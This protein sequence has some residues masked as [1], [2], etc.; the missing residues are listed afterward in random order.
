MRRVSILLNLQ[1]IF[2]LTIQWVVPKCGCASTGSKSGHPAKWSKA[3]AKIKSK[4]IIMSD[5][6]LEDN[7]VA[8]SKMVKGKNSDVGDR[9]DNPNKA[10]KGLKPPAVDDYGYP[11]LHDLNNLSADEPY[12]PCICCVAQ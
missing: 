2:K 7:D 5:Q 11:P 9:D 12:V 6:D 1:L 8:R 10:T 3:S 4:P